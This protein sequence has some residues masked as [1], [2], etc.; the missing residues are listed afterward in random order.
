LA[1]AWRENYWKFIRRDRNLLLHEARSTVAT[2]A[3]I[4][5]IDISIR[6]TSAGEQIPVFAEPQPSQLTYS[7]TMSTLEL[8]FFEAAY[9]DRT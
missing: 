4:D 2:S 5:L 3:T 1:A 6:T 9:P 7:Y 8:S